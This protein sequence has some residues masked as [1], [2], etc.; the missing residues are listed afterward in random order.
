[1]DL[2]GRDPARQMLIITHAGQ[3]VLTPETL[4]DAAGIPIISTMHDI[5]HSITEHLDAGI[6]I[7]HSVREFYDNLKPVLAQIDDNPAQPV[8]KKAFFSFRS[9]R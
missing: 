5:S 1:M 8:G 6:Q 2:L 7:P 3:S 9:K 4:G